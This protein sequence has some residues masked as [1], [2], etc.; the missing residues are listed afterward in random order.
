MDDMS[1]PYEFD[2]GF[3][4]DPKFFP[5]FTGLTDRARYL[6]RHMTRAERLVW[7][8]VRDRRFMGLKFRRQKPLLWFI[9][10]FYCAELKLVIEI[11]GGV[12]NDT[13]AYDETRTEE[14]GKFGVTVF[15][16]TNEE[17]LN[18]LPG[19]LRQISVQIH[20]IFPNNPFTP[21]Q[22]RPPLPVRGGAGGGVLFE[23]RPGS[24]V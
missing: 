8:A 6:R 19:V 13:Q 24:G 1:D 18:D 10:D 11:D 21:N 14:L 20:S 3:F 7:E 5:Y 12:H 15:R 17:I 4:D 9:A 16:F 23:K 22:K 2:D